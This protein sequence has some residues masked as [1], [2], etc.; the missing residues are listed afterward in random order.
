[1]L[2]KSGDGER[3]Y[4]FAAYW[5]WAC[6]LKV[7]SIIASLL[8]LRYGPDSTDSNENGSGIRRG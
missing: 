8:E 3:N 2:I 5:Y 4:W 7:S 1:M 6:G